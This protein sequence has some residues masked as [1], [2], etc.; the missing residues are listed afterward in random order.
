MKKSLTLKETI[1]VA[2]LLFGM[3]F[4]AGNL[5]FPVHLG[6][7]AGA[8]VWGASLG[9]IITGVGIPILG[10]VALGISRSEGLLELSG[11][12]S[13][14]YGIFFTTLLYLTIGPFFAIPR[15]ATV[16]FSLGV[17]PLLEGADQTWPLLIFTAVFFAIVLL[18]S[19]KPNGILTW[20]GKLLN[21]IFLVCLGILVVTAL[22]KPAGTISQ[23]TPDAAYVG[24]NAIYN[25]FLEGYN[26]MD[27]IAGLAFGIIIVN[28][29]RSLKV[30]EPKDIARSTVKSGILTGIVMGLIYLAI[31]IVGTQSR[32]AFELSDNGGIAL[33]QI[34]DYYF[35]RI[36][37]FI[38]AAIG[39]FAC[40][41]TSI[42][43]VTSCGETFEKMFPKGPKYSVWAIIFCVFSFAISN[44]GLTAI[45]AYAVP[46][47][48]FIYP[49][50]ITLILLAIFGRFFDY[51]KKVF[52]CVTYL[53][54]IAAI[55]DMIG[56]L[57]ENVI[58]ALNLTPIIEFAGKFIP[59]QTMGFGWLCPALIGLVIGLI[60]RAVAKKKIVE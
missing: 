31:I 30:E 23:I 24:S 58:T 16:P 38:L 15:C 7:L 56:T 48:M 10:V 53:T 35:G 1:L 8:N 59:L 60:W 41:K 54:L 44:V 26:T 40:L 46:V 51:D 21:P 6:Q 34:A 17:E 3:F 32:G 5:I 2:S 4:G 57:P 42:G 9:F 27:A 11:K 39:T 13:H 33:A 14:G 29:C 22:V 50:A 47:L 37:T 19:L 43:L 49:L 25:G 20:I 36:G 45:I 52:G 28:V 12:V 55:F 18:F